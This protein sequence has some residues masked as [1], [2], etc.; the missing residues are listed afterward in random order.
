M[1]QGKIFQSL[2]GFYDVHSEGKIYR[3][4][5][6]GNFRKRKITPLVGDDV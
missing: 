1:K 3:T 2:S 4:R 6:R 5:A